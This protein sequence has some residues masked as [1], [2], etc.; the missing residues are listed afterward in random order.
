MREYRNTS[1]GETGI[2]MSG[3]QWDEAHPFRSM[4]YELKEAIKELKDQ[5]TDLDDK[6]NT[7]V[8]YRIIQKAGD[9]LRSLDF[10]ELDVRPHNVL[11]AMGVETIGQ[12]T[13]LGPKDLRKRRNCGFMTIWHIQKR[14]K[15]WGLSL[16]ESP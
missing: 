16:K 15:R 8:H 11:R 12:L 1:E 14:L 3:K 4:F 13:A 5:I 10:L 9:P 7:L 2:N 6:F